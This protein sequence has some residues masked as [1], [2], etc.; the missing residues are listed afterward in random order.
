MLGPRRPRRALRLRDRAAA[1][2][3]GPV[4]SR[5]VERRGAAA[6]RELRR[7]LRS[8]SGLTRDP[9]PGDRHPRWPARCAWSRATTTARRRSTPIRSTPRAAGSS[10]ARGRCTS[11]TS[12]APVRAP[13]STSSTS[14]GSATRSTSP[15]RSAA[16][17]ARPGTSNRVLG[18][19]AARAILG[20]AA[21]SDPAL[22]EALV[23]DHGDRIVVSADARV[24]AV[25]VEGWERPT[26]TTSARL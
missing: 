17:C 8:G 21:V 6:A 3:R 16:A 13:R 1:A 24:G 19:G 12:T 25:A 4:S 14:R 18:A 22:V 15:S 11:S 26:A 9:L 23:V 20:S 2:L 7:H 10:R 5:E